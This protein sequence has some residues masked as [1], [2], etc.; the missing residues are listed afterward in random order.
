MKFQTDH[1]HMI[2]SIQKHP[3]RIITI[4]S[5]IRFNK[6]RLFQKIRNIFDGPIIPRRH[7]NSPFGHQLRQMKALINQGF[8]YKGSIIEF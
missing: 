8:F 6:K 2:A 1:R 5:N 7:Q 3:K 4:L